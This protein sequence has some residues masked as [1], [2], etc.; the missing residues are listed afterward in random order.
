VATENRR[1]VFRLEEAWKGDPGGHRVE[2]RAGP[3]GGP[4]APA[5]TSNDRTYV[6]GERYLVFASDLSRRPGAA[7]D[8]GE[9]ARWVDSACSAT[10]PYEPSLD[11]FRP[12]GAGPVSSESGRSLGTA[13]SVGAVVFLAAGVVLAVVLRRR[14]RAGSARYLRL[15]R[16]RIGT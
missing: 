13:V 10:R 11:R 12:T 7:V 3:G 8:Y 14:S 9:G 2:V 6:V 5:A 15:G 1:A 16:G 4:G